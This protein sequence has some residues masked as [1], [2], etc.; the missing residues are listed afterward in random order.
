MQVQMEQMEA[1]SLKDGRKAL[2]KLEQRVRELESELDSEQRRHGETSKNFRKVERRVKEL[3]FQSEEDQKNQT[4]LQE[5]TEKLQGKIKTY[6]R[7]VRCLFLL[8]NNYLHYTLLIF[9]SSVFTEN[10]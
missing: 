9:S 6:K 2:S 3:A 8:T 10:L 4:R 1:S 7:Q 5:L